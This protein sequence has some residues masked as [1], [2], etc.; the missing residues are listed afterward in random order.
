MI[1]HIYKLFIVVLILFSLVAFSGCFNNKQTRLSS[2]MLFVYS[3]TTVKD[4]LTEPKKSYVQAYFNFPSDFASDVLFGIDQELLEGIY[5]PLHFP[6]AD[7]MGLVGV[8]RNGLLGFRHGT[9][10]SH[11]GTPTGDGNWEFIQLNVTFQPNTWYMIR[12]VVDFNLRRFDSVTIQG[13]DVNI[14]IT[15][16]DYLLDYPNYLPFNNKTLT[17]YV[18]AF[19]MEKSRTGSYSVYFDDVEAGIETD[20]GFQVIIRDSFENQT[21]LSDVPFTWPDFNLSLITEY[22]WYKER[23]EALVSIISTKARTGDQACACNARL[24]SI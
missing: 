4:F 8:T 21:S 24:Q 1:K 19:R 12:E 22:L 15:L 18:F 6:G 9:P 11:N 2:A 14:T 20:N 3:D 13:P 17:Y 7:W 10:A 23:P 5:E 16:D